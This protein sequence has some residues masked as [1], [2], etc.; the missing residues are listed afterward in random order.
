MPSPLLPTPLVAAGLWLTLA[1][2]ST[3]DTSADD[4]GGLGG[5]P[6]STS[7]GGAT[8]AGGQSNLEDLAEKGLCRIRA[9]C[10]EEVVDEP[11]LLCEFE[12]R[13][14]ADTLVYSA[15]AGIEIR[16]RSSQEF[17]KKN[18]GLELRTSDGADNPTNLL[19]L[20]RDADWILD[21]AWADRSFMRNRLAFGLYR[22]IGA[23][24]W[25]PQ[26]RYCEF[27]L[28]SEPQGIYVLLESI[29]RDDDRV[30][31][32]L[33]DGSGSTFLVKQDDQGD[34]DLAISSASGG[35]T[36]QLVYP[37]DQEATPTQRQAAQ[38]FLDQL[39][40]A[41]TNGNSTELGHI[42]DPAAMADWL[43]LEEFSRNIDGFNLSLFFA[44]VNGGLAFAIPWDL[45]LSFGQ[46]TIRNGTNESP[47]GWIVN[48]TPLL[49]G[50]SANDDIRSRLGPRWRELR[51][52]HFSNQA[53]TARLDGYAAI[54]DP[55]ALALNFS[56]FP[57]QD[58]D[59]SVVYP[60]YTFYDVTSHAEEMTHLRT[61]IDQRL[62][63]LDA[64]ID[65]YPTE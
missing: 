59:F 32:P 24:R 47:E 50:L 41:L 21:G 52:L 19:G 63:W 44:R 12:V 26:A 3:D 38:R 37:R 57:I 34:L 55:A 49:R 4:P 62:A 14:S 1:C 18:Y 64:N 30:A 7:Q 27:T 56:L 5:G 60:P 46:P 65:L 15:S 28:N 40:A 20:G 2:S 16:G 58:V 36:W 6:M 61:W 31:L 39:G 17:P 13:D 51:A 53:I 9:A 29:K 45:D 33:D 42:L 8:A 48:R 43:L 35:D 22:D 10:P 54:L 23:P 25:A 11:K